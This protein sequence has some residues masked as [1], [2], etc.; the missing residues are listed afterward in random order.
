MKS[1]L[2]ERKFV[3][4][5]DVS[6]WEVL[7]DTGWEDI[8]SSNKTIEY[9]VYELTTTCGIKLQAADDHILFD[10][11]YNE[12]FLKDLRPNN[13]IQGSSGILTVLSIKDLQVKEPMFDLSVNSENHRYYTNGILS[14]NTTVAASYLLWYAMFHPGKNILVLG[15]NASAAMEIMDRIR[16]TY[17]ECPDHIRDGV[18]EYNKLALRF[19]NGSRI[20]SRATTPTAARGLSIHL[21]YLDEFAFVPSNMQDD[22]WSAVSPTLAATDGRIIIT[23]TPNTE[24]DLYA[25]LWFDSQKFI[26]RNGVEITDG[27]GV[28]GFCGL[29]VTWDNHPDRDEKWAEKELEKIGPS[30]FGREHKCSVGDTLIEL[31][32]PSGK[33]LKVTI[34]EAY[35]LLNSTDQK[36]SQPERN[37]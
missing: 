31:K 32:D 20:I 15:N 22:F 11:N 25:R 17:E 33:V 8:T 1:D 13:K 12:V 24:F 3:E 27:T 34:K 7:T 36:P 2:I 26:D 23:S 10:E 9:E 4:Q 19:E 21:L 18:V 6:D 28:N 16:A 29:K 35:D 30:L 37:I 5:F 14:H